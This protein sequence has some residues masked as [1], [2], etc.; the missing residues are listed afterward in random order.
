MVN[1]KRGESLVT[2]QGAARPFRLTAQACEE[3]RALTGMSIIK[4]SSQ[5]LE[6]EV[7]VCKLLYVGLRAGDPSIGTYAEFAADITL[8][9]LIAADTSAMLTTAFGADEGDGGNATRA[10]S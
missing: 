8:N 6:D 1:E 4:A 3:F 2:I 10:T 9:D 7:L 5:M